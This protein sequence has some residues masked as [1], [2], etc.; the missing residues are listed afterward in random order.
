MKTTHV[1]LGALILATML[2][3][4]AV[5][6]SQ[7]SGG[8]LV[9]PFN[10]DRIRCSVAHAHRTKS[11]SF[12]V[13]IYNG[14]GTQVAT[15]SCPAAS[16]GQVCSVAHDPTGT[17]HLCVVDVEGVPTKFVRG[18]LCAEEDTT[19]NPLVCLPLFSK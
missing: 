10:L 3:S 17:G 11:A 2:P 4:L 14:A 1:T 19:F 8:V 13:S 12:T 9:T 15:T 7:L 16:F 18:S 5:A 6:A